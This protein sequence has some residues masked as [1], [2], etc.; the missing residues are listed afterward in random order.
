MTMSSQSDAI[1]LPDEAF[2]LAQ[3]STICTT[4]WQLRLTKSDVDDW[5]SNFSGEVHSQRY[6]RQLALWLLINFVFYNHDE[7]MHLCNLLF[8]YFLHTYLPLNGEQGSR[9]ESANDALLRRVLFYQLGRPGESGGF[10][11][12]HFRQVN[13]L[14][15]RSFVTTPDRIPSSIDTIVFL[16]DVCLS[17]TQARKYLRETTKEFKAVDRVVLTLLATQEARELLTSDNT[18]LIA[19][20]M[21]D[22]RS[23]CFSPRSA[24][25][26]GYEHHKKAARDFACHYGKK[27]YP[28][29]PLGF[30][31]DAYTF[32]F[33]YNT[34][35]N[36]LPI[37]WS[38]HNGWTPIMK[39]YDK[40][41]GKKGA[42]ELGTYV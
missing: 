27:A 13:Q 15:L 6:E 37:F 11:L 35:D 33:Y 26:A 40:Q 4:A 22:E 18:T 17:G 10:I 5:L 25:F 9:I 2:M 8:K 24:V 16:D 21:L 32:A 1:E 29:K 30:N 12:Y 20:H 28:T 38:D 42:Y 7:V 23:K 41:Y 39:R 34:P 31:E 19:A 14:P 36:T 3:L